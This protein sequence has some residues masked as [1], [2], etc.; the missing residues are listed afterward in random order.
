MGGG[1][2][3]K[4]SKHRPA[5]NIARDLERRGNEA[6]N[7][8]RYCPTKNRKRCRKQK[9][10]N[11]VHVHSTKVAKTEKVDRE[12]PSGSEYPRRMRCAKLHLMLSA[13]QA[14]EAKRV[15]SASG[16]ENTRIRVK[17]GEGT[18]RK[19]AERQSTMMRSAERKRE[20]GRERER[21]NEAHRE[22]RY[23]FNWK[24][25]CPRDLN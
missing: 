5:S 15:R 8:F 6:T 12:T 18:E 9:W 20:R 16:I 24:L 3:E 13:Y 23:F 17:R 1:A 22:R 4:S 19:R 10:H 7:I 2:D 25:E 14:S 11:H 21:E